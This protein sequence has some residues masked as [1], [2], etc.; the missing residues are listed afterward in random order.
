MAIKIYLHK[1][2]LSVGY[3]VPSVLEAWFI[4][5]AKTETCAVEYLHI[6]GI[7]E[8]EKSLNFVCA[9]CGERWGSTTP[10]L[11]MMNARHQI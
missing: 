11:L 5:C 2:V 6:D 9:W 10:L 7:Q 1:D 8:T 3:D 4:F